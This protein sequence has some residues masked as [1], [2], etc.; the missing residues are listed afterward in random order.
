MKAISKSKYPELYLK[1]INLREHVNF[2]GDYTYARRQ[3][4]SNNELGFYDKTPI[5]S[6]EDMIQWV[7]KTAP[8]FKSAEAFKI[9]N[10]FSTG[11]K[12]LGALTNTRR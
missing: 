10:N 2:E 3:D 1:G 8:K 11:G 7:V 6:K 9:P 12:V 4:L 5:R